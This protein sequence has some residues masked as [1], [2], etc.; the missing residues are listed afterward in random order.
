[1]SASALLASICASYEEYNKMYDKYIRVEDDKDDTNRK[2]EVRTC[3]T[4]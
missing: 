2:S 3:K 4:C 1:M